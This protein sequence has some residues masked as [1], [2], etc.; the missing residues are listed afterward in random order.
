MLFDGIQFQL[1]HFLLLSLFFSS[2]DMVFNGHLYTVLKTNVSFP[3]ALATVSSLSSNG[4][5]GHLVTTTDEAELYFVF[6]SPMQG[7]WLGVSDRAI[8]GYWAIVSG[9][10]SGRVAPALLWAK[11]SSGGTAENCADISRY[12]VRDLNCDNSTRTV[13]IEFECN[14]PHGTADVSSC[15]CKCE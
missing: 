6:D 2:A 13:A 9:P 12:S 14:V 8:E 11:E 10:E 3:A 1:T 5:E 7:V 4:M 15:P